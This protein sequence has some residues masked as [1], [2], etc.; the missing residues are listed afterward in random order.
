MKKY[1]G[2]LCNYCFRYYATKKEVSKI[3][4]FIADKQRLHFCNVLC[5]ELYK[6]RYFPEKKT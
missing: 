2:W 4:A 5:L 3:I 1:E 6:Q